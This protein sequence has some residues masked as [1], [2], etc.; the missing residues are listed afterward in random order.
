MNVSCC[1]SVYLLW[2]IY[3]FNFLSHYICPGY[4]E[5][6][7]CRHYLIV[8]KLPRCVKLKLFL[9]K[10]KEQEKE[11]NFSLCS[12]KEI[13]HCMLV[14]FS[15]STKNKS[16][17]QNQNTYIKISCSNYL[18]W[19][20]KSNWP[21]HMWKPNK[22]SWFLFL[23]GQGRNSLYMTHYYLENVWCFQKLPSPIFKNLDT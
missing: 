23:I 19:K 11:W 9:L 3:I 1:S 6:Q 15:S 2:Y 21:C 8:C 12:F 4:L 20:G 10:V 16:K 22:W 7:I 18:N 17:S 13:L 14:L 5:H